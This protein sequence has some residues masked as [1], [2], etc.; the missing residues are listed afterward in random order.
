ME[1]EIYYT[2][3]ES[4][5]RTKESIKRNAKEVAREIINNYKQYV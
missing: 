2:L 3:E 4:E 1:K 5:Q